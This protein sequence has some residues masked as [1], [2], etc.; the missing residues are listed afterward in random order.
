MRCY[1][2]RRDVAQHSKTRETDV[3]RILRSKEP[4]L[5]ANFQ[6]HPVGFR[7]ADRVEC[8]DLRF[9]WCFTLFL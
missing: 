8:V 1:R 5:E 7:L 6:M 3:G 9:Y 2:G 4:S